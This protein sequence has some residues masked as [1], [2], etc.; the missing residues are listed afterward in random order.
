MKY[1]PRCRRVPPN[2]YVRQYVEEMTL[3]AGGEAQSSCGEK[4]AI[5]RAKSRNGNRQRHQPGHHPQDA[6][7]ECHGDGFGCH[8]LQWGHDGQVGDV[9]QCVAY[10]D[11]RD[12]D[13]YAAGEVSEREEVVTIKKSFLGDLKYIFS[14]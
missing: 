7:A 6:V 8:H 3:S 5:G 12:A 11:E 4:G 13:Y 2:M 9:Y 10:R 14:P 1:Q